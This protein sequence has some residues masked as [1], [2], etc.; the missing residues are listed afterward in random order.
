MFEKMGPL[1]SYWLNYPA[2]SALFSFLFI[3]FLCVYAALIGI[4]FNFGPNHE[5]QGF[6]NAVN[7][8]PAF[9]IGMPLIV[10][11]VALLFRL[12]NNA[13]LSLD[14]ILI[15][16]DGATQ[17]FSIEFFEHFGKA[18]KYYIVPIGLF[19][20]LGI[21]LGADF[22]SIFAPLGATADFVEKDWTSVGYA[23]HLDTPSW[24]FLLFNI[25]AF[26]AEGLFAYIGVV[27][28]FSM[29]YPLYLFAK[30]NIGEDD[31]TTS[32][33]SFINQ[34]TLKWN[35]NDAH[36]RCGLHKLDK[37]FMTYV[38]LIGIGIV[39]ALASV[40]KNKYTTGID[41]GSL[42]L[43]VGIGLLLPL[44]FVWIILPYWIKFPAKLPPEERLSTEL[45]G[46]SLPDPKPWPLGSEKLS[47]G[48]L[49][50]ISAFWV[51][52]MKH[53][54]DYIIDKYIP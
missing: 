21:V 33:R 27:T 44:S 29:A 13:L 53:G 49:M 1:H 50:A 48:F 47:W 37:V 23:Q 25:L 18:W 41:T 22:N 16:N 42:I 5:Y 45:K 4:A 38:G 8:G 10:F 26:F 46:L 40:L 11:V 31:K 19:I 32:S 52:L 34:Y 35:Y 15:A 12:L 43:I 20:S 6:V 28:I 36:G 14:N 54:F 51:Y 30:F 39:L 24:L 7:W 17:P 2:K 9:L 3:G